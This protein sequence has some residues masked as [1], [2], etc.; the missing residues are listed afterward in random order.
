MLRRRRNGTCVVILDHNDILSCDGQLGIQHVHT[1][2][3]T[4]RRYQVMTCSQKYLH[5]RGSKPTS[6]AATLGSSRPSCGC[7]GYGDP[8]KIERY[9]IPKSRIVRVQKIEIFPRRDAIRLALVAGQSSTEKSMTLISINLGFHALQTSAQV[10]NDFCHKAFGKVLPPVKL[11]NMG[12]FKVRFR[13]A[14]S[15]AVRTGLE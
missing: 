12:G 7:R 5:R 15:V 11:M 13:Q 3:S 1:A 9:V 2:L 8:Q 10:T 4:W 14:R 6:S